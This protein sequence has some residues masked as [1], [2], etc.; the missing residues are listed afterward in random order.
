MTDLKVLAAQ[1]ERMAAAPNEHTLA[2]AFKMIAELAK[3]LDQK[4]P[5]K[6]GR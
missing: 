2:D 4:K 6:H 1:C 3:A 5:K